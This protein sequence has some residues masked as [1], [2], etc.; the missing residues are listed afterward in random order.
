MAM[1]RLIL[2]IMLV[3]VHV[4]RGI[5]LLMGVGGGDLRVLMV[6]NFQAILEEA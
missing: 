5:Q 3:H 1:C 2:G 4:E 6:R